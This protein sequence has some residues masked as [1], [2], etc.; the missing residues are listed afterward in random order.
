MTI[1]SQNNSLWK[2]LVR[3]FV[4]GAFTVLP[5]VLTVVAISWGVGF[6]SDLVGPD[7]FLGHRLSTVG[8][9][10]ATNPMVAYALGWLSL[11]VVVF[12]VGFL[13]E[14]GLRGFIRRVIDAVLRRVPL[15]GKVYET[16]QQLVNMLDTGGDD[17]LKGM[18][19]VYCCF[20]DRGGVGVLALLPKQDII[21]INGSDYYVVLVPQSPVPIG[22]GL[23]FMPV[24]SV[25][26]V[27]MTVDKLMSVY[28][29][30][31]VVAPDSI[32]EK[33]SNRP[34]GEADVD[35]TDQ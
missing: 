28:V 8:L 13:V 7:T 9:R 11:A 21:K 25:Q 16:S 30:M 22:G 26:Q 33:T 23:L 19:V 14:S 12:V 2:R 27:D 10:F 5:L 35:A 18:S 20:G 29:S 6:L 24:G 15:V 34:D 32:P 1:D 31:G 17:K 4:A 3:Y